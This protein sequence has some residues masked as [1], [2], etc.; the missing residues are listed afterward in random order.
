MWF[1]VCNQI[2]SKYRSVNLPQ[3]FSE[4][5]FFRN[6]LLWWIKENTLPPDFC[7]NGPS[8]PNE[9]R[10]ILMP[11]FVQTNVDRQ[12]SDF[13]LLLSKKHWSDLIFSIKK[14]H[15]SSFIWDGGWRCGLWWE[16]GRACE[17][18]GI[19]VFWRE[20]IFWYLVW[21]DPHFLVVARD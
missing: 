12:W 2:V 11:F 19:S 6:I 4:N 10:R 17:N 7:K 13:L 20:N 16:W 15:K 5:F 14:E 8:P 1:T 3:L 21:G 9:S 18:P